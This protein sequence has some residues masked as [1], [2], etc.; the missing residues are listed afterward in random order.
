MNYNSIIPN[1]LTMEI[2]L[3]SG[4]V[5][6]NYLTAL[7]T[8]KLSYSSRNFE[9]TQQHFP[10]FRNR[11]GIDRA[12]ESP[13]VTSKRPNVTVP[14]LA[15]RLTR[16]CSFLPQSPQVFHGI[17]GHLRLAEPRSGDREV[18]AAPSR[19]GLHRP[20]PAA[21]NARPRRAVIRSRWLPLACQ[22]ERARKAGRKE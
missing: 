10:Q 9:G 2:V 17:C 16:K 8:Y 12:F 20:G 5:L 7:F 14:A 15:T 4:N 21:P 1:I 3:N 6:Y 18:P 11:E 19:A 22:Q 13:R